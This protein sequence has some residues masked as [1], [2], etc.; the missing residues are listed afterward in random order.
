MFKADMKEKEDNTVEIS[1][2][3]HV[4]FEEFLRFCYTGKFSKS[5][6]IKLFTVADKVFSELYFIQV[7]SYI[8]FNFS[9][10]QTV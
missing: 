4:V 5:L 10:V 1:D 2:I 8:T 7:G 9:M 3:D 6:A